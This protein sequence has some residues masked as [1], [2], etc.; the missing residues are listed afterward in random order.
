MQLRLDAQQQEFQRAVTAW[1]NAL[2]PE[3][4]DLEDEQVLAAWEEALIERGWQA[5]K[6]PAAFGGTGWGMVEKY[7][8]EQSVG[9]LGLPLMLRGAG[10]ALLGPI[11]AGFGTPTQQQEFLPPILS[12]QVNWCQGYS[13]PGAGSDLASLR[14]RAIA[15]GDG[16]RVSGE[17][18]WTSEAHFADWMFTLTRSS[19][20]GRKQQGITFLLIDMHAPGV[21]VEP[22]ITLDGHHTLNRVRLDS[23]LVPAAHRVGAEGA[24][25]T[26]AKGLLNHERTGLAFLSLSQR[27]LRTARTALAE[28]TPQH[29]ETRA[30]RV[31]LEQLQVQIDALATTEMRVLAETAGGQPPTDAASILKL[32]GTQLL[33]AITEVLIEC[34]AWQALPYPLD[35]RG[36]PP[37]DRPAPKYAQ[38]EQAQYLIARSASIAGGSDE[39]QY[40][41]IAKHVLGL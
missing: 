10:I 2:F 18:I 24:G 14:T 31:R 36:L 3:P 1:L 16:Y 35:D 9:A 32:K 7:L 25:W 19:D 27:K 30:L 26:V 29:P 6:W 28:L 12:K 23:V 8:W 41:V 20:A 17:K 38:A 34:G 13:E 37:L 21:S 15:T 33:Q 11:L 22:I 4:P 5:Y 40:G 39:I